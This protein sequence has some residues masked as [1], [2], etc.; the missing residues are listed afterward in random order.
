MKHDDDKFALCNDDNYDK[1]GE[2]VEP[3]DRELRHR[4]CRLHVSDSDDDFNNNSK[5]RTKN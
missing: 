1:D 3:S 5:K 2:K 4:T